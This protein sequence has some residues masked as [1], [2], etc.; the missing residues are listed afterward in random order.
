VYTA[1]GALAASFSLGDARS[2]H[3]AVRLADG[4]VLVAGGGATTAR[5]IDGLFDSIALA[6]GDPILPRDDAAAIL[7]P[8][9]KVLIAGGFLP[10]RPFYVAEG[11]AEL[12][13]PLAGGGS[14][15]LTEP[16]R[17]F[18]PSQ[19][20]F[21]P[22]AILLPGDRIMVID[23]TNGVYQYAQIYRPDPVRGYVA[24]PSGDL[25]V[26]ATATNS[27]AVASALPVPG[28]FGIAVERGRVFMAERG[29]S[30][31]FE[32]DPDRITSAFP[33]NVLQTFAGLGE[34]Y[35]VAASI[36]PAGDGRAY[37]ADDAASA[38]GVVDTATR[39]FHPSSPILLGAESGPFGVDAQS[40]TRVAVT[41][42][43]GQ[44]SVID[45]SGEAPS[46]GTLDL[47]YTTTP[48]GIAFNP[49]V[50]ELAYATLHASN[51]LATLGIVG[52]AVEE[53]NRQATGVRP[54]GVAVTLDGL[55]VYVANAGSDDVAVFDAAGNPILDGTTPRR[56]VVGSEPGGL[57]LTPDGRRLYVVNVGRP[58]EFAASI[59]VIDTA[60][61]T[62]VAGP[63]LPGGPVFVPGQWAFA[64]GKFI[65]RF[66]AP[67]PATSDLTVE[68]L[69]VS[70]ATPAVGDTFDYSVTVRNNGPDVASSVVVDLGLSAH[71]SYHAIVD[72]GAFH[73]CTIPV[74]SCAMPSMAPGEST[75]A[76]PVTVTA[77]ADTSGIDFTVSTSVGGFS[78]TVT[79][80]PGGPGVPGA[81]VQVF[82]ASDDGFIT[83][84]F[85]DA[86]G[87]YDLTARLRI[88]RTYK[89]LA[90]APGFVS[91]YHA[92][93]PTAAAADPVA[94]GDAAPVTVD[95]ALL[96]GGGITGQIESGSAPVAGALV[97]FFDDAT[98][99]FREATVSDSHGHYSAGRRLQPGPTY[100]IRVRS[101]DLATAFY[102]GEVTFTA[103]DAVTVAAAGADETGKNFA[104]A[105]GGRVTGRVFVDASGA[106]GLPGAVVELFD[107][108][109]NLVVASTTTGE[110]GGYDTGAT[111]PALNYRIRARKPGYVHTLHPA[112]MDF[113]TATVVS[114]SAGTTVA[115]IDIAMP[116]GG[117]ITGAIRERGTNGGIPPAIPGATVTVFRVAANT[118][119]GI[120]T[121]T[122]DVA[123]HFAI[124]GLRD[125][126]WYLRVSKPGF[127]L[128]FWS[129]DPNRPAMDSGSVAPIQI[130]G[131]NT[132]TGVDLNLAAGGGTRRRRWT[133]PWDVRGSRW[134]SPS[135]TSGARCTTSARRLPSTGRPPCRADH[136][137]IRTSRSS[138][139][140]R[141]PSSPAVTGASAARSASSARARIG[142]TSTGATTPWPSSP[143]RTERR[144]SPRWRAWGTPARRAWTTG[145]STPASVSARTAGS[146]ATPT[147]TGGSICSSA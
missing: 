80:G 143:R 77:G 53:D 136:S 94:I 61:D 142:R 55:K 70:T 68:A 82:D 122:T 79:D 100:K 27:V 69:A 28:G 116:P 86:D 124:Q 40:P 9:G 99:T 26:L 102:D 8:T 141:S 60:S 30:T 56:I 29:G 93:K 63:S 144:C 22:V 54:A 39:A 137:P 31:L 2:G 118:F 49:R 97:D 24:R 51:Q 21:P 15:S 129:G 62:V 1:D 33:D 109:T 132:V 108:A 10:A 17:Q 146:P 18:V 16:P 134:V 6:G 112:A 110:D 96:R 71:V 20:Q 135:R 147:S 127:V 50:P 34:L 101:S 81:D 75:T 74:V 83:N 41:Q 89:I 35:G 117:T 44:V 92:G 111:V 95:F 105:A 73:V 87:L 45:T 90:R 84:A 133:R 57:A 88:G 145:S 4:R 67:G 72:F 59:S 52:T 103:A 140:P 76:D 130:D 64:F 65:G 119:Q 104:L 12:F 48:Y 107:A 11:S 106:P 37:A 115:D 125:G 38:L 3:Q 46:I 123:G 114:V 32:L 7:L 131:G 13:D 36:A 113:T 98:N 91:Q 120:F 126:E 85:T 66:D 19:L 14:F 58:P 47:G 139:W 42:Q 128:G 23:Q 25:Y 78:G 43:A 5:L 138:T 121:T